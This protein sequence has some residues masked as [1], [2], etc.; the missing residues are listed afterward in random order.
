MADADADLECRRLFE[1]FAVVGLLRGAIVDQTLPAALPRSRAQ[2]G[3][4]GGGAGGFGAYAGGSGLEAVP[5]PE[6]FFAARSLASFP[7]PVPGSRRER[8]LLALPPFCFPDGIRFARLDARA[9]LRVPRFGTSVL[10]REDF[11]RLY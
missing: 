11:S 5:L 10:T 2:A 9:G 7:L 1:A 8:S 4:G 6:R 3:V